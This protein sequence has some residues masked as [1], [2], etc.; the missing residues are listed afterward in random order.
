MEFRTLGCY[1]LYHIHPLTG[2]C[3]LL[4]D[5]R[6]Q[7]FQT[8]QWVIP[9]PLC[10]VALLLIEC[11]YLWVWQGVQG[12]PD[13][14]CLWRCAWA[15]QVALVVESPLASAGDTR[16]VGSIP[17]LGRSPGGGHHNP[18]QYSFLENPVGR[19]AW[20]ATVYR[21]SKSR[22]L[23]KQLSTQA[24]RCPWATE[25]VSTGLC[26]LSQ[27]GRRARLDDKLWMWVLTLSL[28]FYCWGV[29]FSGT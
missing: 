25:K 24:E 13:F 10:W 9:S 5:R 15:P 28:F 26:R 7:I 2:L 4:S 14:A 23:L 8:W 12:L 20:W 3:A 16:D 27:C 11:A 22:T 29:Q 21:V 1:P 19:G 6:H 17:G 18:L